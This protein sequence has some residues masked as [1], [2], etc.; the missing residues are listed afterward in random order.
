MMLVISVIVALAILGVLLQILGGLNFGVGNPVDVMKDG[1]NKVHSKG[2]GIIAADKK[3]TFEPGKPIYARDV[4]ADLP[5]VYKNVHFL[6]DQ[7][8]D[9]YF[10][11]EGSSEDASNGYKM[12]FKNKFDANVVVC[13]DGARDPPV[14]CVAMA[15]TVKK[16]SDICDT[17]CVSATTPPVSGPTS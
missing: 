16:A 15:N 12:D 3:V 11:V 14:Y 10:N 6:W 1:M 9:Q 2:F 4:V 7:S 13:G 8:L 5:I 17:K